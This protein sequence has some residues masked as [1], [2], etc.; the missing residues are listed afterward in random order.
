MV[1][2]SN[3]ALQTHKF[4]VSVSGRRRHRR[5]RRRRIPQNNKL[6]RN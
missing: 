2:H 4:E 3:V 6:I 5:R 1:S